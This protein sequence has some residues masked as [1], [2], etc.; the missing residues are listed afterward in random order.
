MLEGT[1]YEKTLYA[2]Q[3][4]DFVDRRLNGVLFTVFERF[5]KC[6]PVLLWSSQ[7][8]QEVFRKYTLGRPFLDKKMEQFRLVRKE[9][10]VDQL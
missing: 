1:H 3:Y 4:D 2:M 6:N 10:G 7:R 9:M 5:V 8:M